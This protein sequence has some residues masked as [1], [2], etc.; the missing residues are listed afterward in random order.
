MAHGA[1]ARHDLGAVDHR[2]SVN[3]LISLVTYAIAPLVMHLRVLV[4]FQGYP[5]GESR[6]RRSTACH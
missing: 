4:S 5:R 6:N 3:T 1:R 2:S